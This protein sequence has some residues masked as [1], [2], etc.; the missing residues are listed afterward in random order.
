MV[1]QETWMRAW[2]PPLAL[3]TAPLV[4]AAL[5]VGLI[6]SH[7][8]S[9]PVQRPSD[10]VVPFQAEPQSA[11]VPTSTEQ[12]ETLFVAQQPNPAPR[13]R[14]FSPILEREPQPEPEQVPPPEQV[15]ASGHEEMPFDEPE[16]VAT[17]PFDSMAQ[18]SNSA[19]EA[20]T[21]RALRRRGTRPRS[22]VDEPDTPPAEPAPQVDALAE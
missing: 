13:A 4:V 1:Q 9:Q 3:A 11:A 15:Q 16:P 21:Q 10:D 7:I 6:P 14:G 8:G 18:R 5:A 20:A 2:G 22:I 17:R 19:A 12:K